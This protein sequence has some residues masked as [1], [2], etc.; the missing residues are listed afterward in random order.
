MCKTDH[1]KLLYST[2]SSA[3]CSVMTGLVG[4]GGG[5]G[6]GGR[7]ASKG[8]DICILVVDSCGC[9]AETNTIL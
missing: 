9:T 7:E 5:V 3:G 2:R 6:G 4:A 8:G 1:G